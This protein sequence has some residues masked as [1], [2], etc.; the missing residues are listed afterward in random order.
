[1]QVSRYKR[2]NYQYQ[3]K[4]NNE[5]E[6]DY[7]SLGKR[8]DKCFVRMY[9]KTK[10]VIEQGYKPWFINEWYYNQLISRYDYYVYLICMS[11]AIGSILILSGCSSMQNMVKMCFL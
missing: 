5:Y 9:L 3:F 10:E 6:N 4:P 11:C 7:I 8:N 2:I 1:M